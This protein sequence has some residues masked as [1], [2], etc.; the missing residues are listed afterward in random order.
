MHPAAMES[1]TWFFLF[2][3]VTMMTAGGLSGMF[4]LIVWTNLIPDMSSREESQ[5]IRSTG[6]SMR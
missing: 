4:M 3:N 6:L 2:S 1:S 5:K